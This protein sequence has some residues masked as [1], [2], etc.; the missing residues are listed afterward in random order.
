MRILTALVL[1]AMIVGTATAG[2]WKKSI[3]ALR[4]VGPDGRG[5]AAAARAW[6]ELAGADVAQLPELLAGMDGAG[7][8]AHNWLRSAVDAVLEHTAAEKKAVP[9][10]ALE[11]FLRDRRHDAQARRLAYELIQSKDPT[12][13]ERLLPGMLDDPSPELRR[14]AIARLLDQAEKTAKTDPKARGLDLF[15]QALAAARDNE[16][17]RTCA[18]R[19]REL[20]Q[21]IDVGAHLGLVMDW[22]VIGPFANANEKGIDTVYAPER[23]IDLAAT[24]DGTSGKVRWTPY[25]SSDEYGIVDLNKALGEGDKGTAYAV[26]EFTSA[27]ERP[28]EIRIGCYNMF[29]MWVNGDMVLARSDAFT[30]M[31]LDHYV[32]QARL[33]AGRNVI[34]L[35]LCKSMFPGVPNLWRFQLRVCD[36]T[37]VAILSTTRPSAAKK[38]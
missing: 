13:P 18:R 29:K 9:V 38:S 1:V 22:H 30:G 34:L 10:A 25:V 37:G 7:P 16:Q 3:Q 19:L 33:K 8:V 20:G 4:E 2:D 27:S 6:K 35:K 28:V 36:A 31:S 14:D 24:A 26:A 15:R 17:I 23:G 11:S 32:A 21:P 12:A 5:S